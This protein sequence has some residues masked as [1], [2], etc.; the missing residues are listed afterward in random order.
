MESEKSAENNAK[1]EF[2][3]SDGVFCLYF[4]GEIPFRHFWTSC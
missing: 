3:T 1:G 4:G 2:N